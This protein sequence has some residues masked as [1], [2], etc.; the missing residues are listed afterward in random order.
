MLTP[1]TVQQWIVVKIEDYGLKESISKISRRF[2]QSVAFV[3]YVSF[4]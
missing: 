4:T 3:Y 2:Q 1:T